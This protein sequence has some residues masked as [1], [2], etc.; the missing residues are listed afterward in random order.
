MSGRGRPG[1]GAVTA[2]L[3]YGS[4]VGFALVG[5]VTTVIVARVLGPEERGWYFL[6]MT[7]GLGVFVA[8]HLSLDQGAF[9]AIA[10]RAATACQLWRPML[11]C[12]TSALAVALG[13]YAVLAGTGLL[14]DGVPSATVV[15]AALLIPVSLVQ[16]LAGGVVY[17]LGRAR[18][19]AIGL[20]T[21][22]AIQLAGTVA[23]AVADRLDSTT[24][25]GV[26]VLSTGVGAW[27]MLAALSAA[28]RGEQTRL[29]Q[30]GMVELL[31][32]SLRN[33]LGVASI[34]LARRADVLVV[35]VYVSAGDLGVYTLAVTLA[36]FVLLS[37]DTIAQAALGH[38]GSL[39]RGDSGRLSVALAAD[40]TRIALAQ[41]VLLAALGWPILAV[42]FGREWLD[43]YP[44][45]LA[46]LPGIVALA[47]VRPLLA[48]FVRSG[49]SLETSLA[50]AAAAAFKIAATALVVK[51]FGL[52]T[53]GVVSSVAWIAA[54]VVIMWRMRAALGLQLWAPSLVPGVLRRLRGA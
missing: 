13:G 26:L 44:M 35:S 10:E 9:W 14:L 33:H 48:S 43:A 22:A 53:V 12:G 18:V 46:L 25:L 28:N 8:V 23:L 15:A 7:V 11:V 17:A 45:V 40:S 37:A 30:F 24:A 31:G 34:W 19:A 27:P 21:A 16:Q 29:A 2:G 1:A 41:V 39:E 42:G 32:V 38:Q 36:E 52:V 5:V 51:P 3:L 54:A 47:Y 20:L 49:R 50:I 6:A 4:R